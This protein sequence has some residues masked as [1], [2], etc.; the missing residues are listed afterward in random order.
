MTSGSFASGGTN[1]P[2]MATIT[3]TATETFTSYVKEV[4]SYIPNK[5]EIAQFH[6]SS[7][8]GGYGGLT[9]LAFYALLGIVILIYWIVLR[10]VR[11]KNKTTYAPSTN[12]G[13]VS[14]GGADKAPARA[15]TYELKEARRSLYYEGSV[16]EGGSPFADPRDDRNPLGI[17]HGRP[18]LRQDSSSS[19]GSPASHLRDAEYSQGRSETPSYSSRRQYRDSRL[20]Y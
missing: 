14:G 10:C 6:R 18:A 4:P 13:V 19:R 20:A 15:E 12:A 1:Q 11:N 3:V 16:V 17:T 2:T 7:R 8:I 5:T 9:A